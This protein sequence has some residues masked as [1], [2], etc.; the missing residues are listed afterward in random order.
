ME[1]VCC[2]KI[3]PEK[4]DEKTV[5]WSARPFVKGRIFSFLHMPLNF[6]S[7]M[8]KLTSAI[9][10]SKAVDKDCIW[11]CDENSKW[12]A[13]LYVSCRKE[14]E[15]CENVTMSGTYLCKV[16]EGPYKNMRHWMIKMSQYVASQDKECKQLYMWYTTCP[17][18]A[19][20]YD[21]NYVVLLAEV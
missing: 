7:V 10:K 19:K 17:K 2:P 9:K 14:V 13:D 1:E 12:G 5:K 4:W 11:L 20:K 6:G 3:D 16:F 21:K 18:C 15:G 8:S